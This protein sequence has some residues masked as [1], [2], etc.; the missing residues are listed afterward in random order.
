MANLRYQSANRYTLLKVALATLAS[1]SALLIV[2][3]W[4]TDEIYWTAL[5][6]L[7]ALG[8]AA[9]IFL[10]HSAPSDTTERGYKSF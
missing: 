1:T 5:I 4:T 2:S 8:Y 7:V 9:S 10:S 3:R 6:H